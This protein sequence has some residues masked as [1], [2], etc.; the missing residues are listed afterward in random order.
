MF[1]VPRQRYNSVRAE[2]IRRKTAVSLVKCTIIGIESSLLL[3][4]CFI[5][6]MLV[7]RLPSSFLYETKFPAS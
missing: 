1:F 3:A 5:E 6:T 2:F 4:V 7:S